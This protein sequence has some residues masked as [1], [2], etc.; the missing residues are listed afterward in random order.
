MSKVSVNSNINSQKI[1]FNSVFSWM[2][3]GL[4]ATG[5]T[6]FYIASSQFLINLILGNKLIFFGLIILQL[7]LVG[8]LSA[9]IK[10]F[11]QQQASMIFI[12]YSILNG[13]T[14]SSL[15]LV[16]TGASVAQ[17]FFIT[18]GTFAFMSMYGYTTKSDLS[19]LGELMFMGLIGIVIASVVNFFMRSSALY[20]I[21]SY[22]GVA[23]FVGLTAWDVQKLKLLSNEVSSDEELKK[24]SIYGALILYLDF[25]NLFIFILRVVGNRRN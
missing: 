19:K 1:F 13:V 21:I 8:G 9:N 10:K 24:L 2:T 23:V 3:L 15:L 14:L 16:Y 17:A 20:W 4:L 5:A 12:L 7:F 18:G 22:A 11:T 6:A 25:I